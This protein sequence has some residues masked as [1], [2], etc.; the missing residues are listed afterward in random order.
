MFS[1]H[2]VDLSQSAAA[3]SMAEY[4]QRQQRIAEQ[5]GPSSLLIIPN[6][7]M[8]Q[9]SG[10]VDYPF[11]ASSD[12]LYFT[13]W[14]APESLCCISLQ[15]GEAKTTLFV[16]PK[17]KVK[18]IWTGIRSGVEGAKQ[19]FPIDEALSIDN[20]EAELGVMLQQFSTIY[21]TRGID[22]SLDEIV[23]S[24]LLEVSRM[25][26]KTGAGPDNLCDPRHLIA[27]MRLIKSPAEIALMRES[28]LIA[29]AAHIESMKHSTAGIMEYQLQAII[30]GCFK[31]NGC[32]WSY[33]SI[34]GGGDNATVLH[35]S[36]ND[37]PVGD[38]EMVLIDAGCEVSGYASDITRTWPV[39]GKF[40]ENQK[41]IYE[42]VLASQMAAIDA[43]L[44]GSPF[45]AP[46]EAAKIVLAQGLL[47]LGIVRGPTLEDAMSA[48]QLGQFYMHNT[49]HWLGLDVHDVGVYAPEGEPRVLREGMVLTVEPGLYFG[50]WR[51]D[52][53]IDEKWAGIGVRIEDDILIT[54]SG[55]EVLTADC[56]KRVE[57]LEE[58]IG[59][60]T[61]C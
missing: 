13:G 60:S 12:L 26:Q 42:L 4:R 50:G 18:E 20:L 9:R 39:N 10:D 47:D 45:N 27:E 55:N 2:G 56:P 1:C 49:S 21:H 52:I 32:D 54:D 33:P 36:E 37:S 51:D 16:Q 22:S 57:V 61:S 30:E 48:E 44:P 19:N 6:N 7:Q 17:D 11:R 23:D 46:H 25:R 5:C 15:D 3:I 28:A 29:S 8:A 40:S 41:T 24:A 58:I 31:H 14:K 34:V 59:S 53:E 43:C 38:G 35:Y